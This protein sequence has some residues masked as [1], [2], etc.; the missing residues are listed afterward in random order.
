MKKTTTWAATTFF[1]VTCSSK[2]A[3][4]SILAIVLV[5][6][7]ASSS[8]V[9]STYAQT[10]TITC[11]C[12]IFRLDDVQDQWLDKVQN[13]V[14][15]TF[16]DT[17]TPLTTGMIMNLYGTDPL[18]V[19]EIQQG[20]D[21]GLFELALHGWNHV[22]Y[23]MLSLDEQQS[24]LAQANAK[25]QAI[26]HTTSNIFIPPYN[27]RN[28]DTLTAM[29]NIGLEIMSADLYYEGNPTFLPMTYPQ[30]DP[31]GIISLPYTVNNM[32]EIKPPGSN[33]KTAAQ[34]M[35]EVDAS[36]AER[37]WAVI[38][39]HPQDFAIY[40]KSTGREENAVNNTQLSTLED[41]INQLNS[42]G[43]RITSYNE[44]VWG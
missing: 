35:S 30:D 13:A 38:M 5:L 29:S 3:I 44:L 25:L 27:A 42:D 43:I 17:G 23:R 36:I 12:V 1:S 15:G 34:L 4:A 22:N 41:L 33:G 11:K 24:T 32:D 9:K 20:Y 31:S 14:L 16:I 28:D 37:G 39:L 2:K 10:A 21:L 19:N 7:L 26:H 6:S 8:G 40:D 18:V